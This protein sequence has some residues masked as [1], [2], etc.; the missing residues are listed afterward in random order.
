MAPIEAQ[1]RDRTLDDV[2]KLDRVRRVLAA[3]RL[4][5]VFDDFEQNLSRPGGGNYLDPTVAHAL[6]A[7]CDSAEVGAVLVTSRYPLPDPNDLLV[8]IPI[9]PLSPSELRRLFLR[10]PALRDLDP[11]DRRFL[12][13]TVG[14]HPRL[15]EFVD[16]L[17]R[18]GRANL[19]QVQAKLRD[20]ARIEG[21]D[22]TRPRPLGGWCQ[23]RFLDENGSYEE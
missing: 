1:L 6:S 8:E 11:E 16:A 18:G 21:I 7:L 9:P 20:L 14:G 19:K 23:T 12:Q 4:L 2:H 5:L 17:L 10:L 15:I 22:L 3:H 13:R